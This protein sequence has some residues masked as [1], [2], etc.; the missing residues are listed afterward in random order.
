[1]SD[2]TLRI[3]N[4]SIAL[5]ALS[6]ISSGADCFFRIEEILK[7]EITKYEKEKEKEI[8]WP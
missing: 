4:L 3:K 7:D 6:R 2:T 1:V 5:E 8:Q